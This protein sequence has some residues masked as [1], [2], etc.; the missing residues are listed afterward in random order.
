MS[1]DNDQQSSGGFDL[2]HFEKNR[3]FQGKLMTALDMATEQ[4]YHTSR[5]ETINKLTTGSG[6]VSGLT[7]TDFEDE[8]DRLKVT[9]EPGVAIDYNGRP[10]VVRNPTTRS[11][12]TP[13]GDEVYFF[14]EYDE[15][16]KDPVPVPGADPLSGEES[17]ESR[18]LE[19]FEVT[20][21]ETAPSSYK[22]T[23]T[24]DFPDFEHTDKSPNELANEIVGSYH[25]DNRRDIGDDSDSSVFIG[26][27]KQTPEGHWRPGEETKRRPFAYDTDMLFSLLLTHITDTDN[28]H[29]TRIGEPTAYI[30]SELDQIEGFAVR[31][32][33]LRTEMEDLREELE[34]HTQYSAHKSL[35]TAVRYFDYAAETFKEDGEISKI[36]LRLTEQTR[37]AIGDEVYTDKETYIQFVEELLGDVQ[38]MGDSLEGKA[39]EMSYTQFTQAVE[40][41][42]EALE[43]DASIIQI[44]TAFDRVGEAAEL[45]QRRYE[46]FPDNEQ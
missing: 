45:L 24:A 28:P 19:V 33:Q 38:T 2:R 3:Y 23:Q 1:H 13:E 31:L 11:V 36:A 6:I 16:S 43:T 46:A 39:T 26:S 7:I 15:E 44:T 17:E 34:V 5:L 32:Q 8:G 29:S 35:K 25:E 14:L 4:H 21:R 12:P 30:E 41:L 10:I 9:I 18:I 22:T 27:F 20:A 37:D 40:T 42:E